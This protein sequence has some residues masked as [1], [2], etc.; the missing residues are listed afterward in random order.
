MDILYTIVAFLLLVG[1]IV[2]IHEGGH[3]IV[4]RMCGIKMMEFSIGFGPKIFSKRFGKDNTLFTLRAFPLGGFVKPFDQSLI[5]EQEW[6][7]VS[8]KDKK[9]TFTNA[10]RSKKALMVFGGP[11]ANFVLAFFLYLIALTFVGAKGYEPIIY[12]ISPESP[13]A[14]TTLLPGEKITEVNYNKVKLNGDVYPPLIN[15]MIQG[16][17]VVISTDKQKNINVDLSGINLR[18]VEK[19]AYSVLGLYFEGNIGDVM[20]DNVV[21]DSPASKAGLK[22]QDIILSVNGKELN[23]INKTIELIKDNPEKELSFVVLR[24]EEKINLIVKPEMVIEKNNEVG[25]VGASLSLINFKEPS[26]VYYDFNEAVWGSFVKVW[27]SSYTTLVSI[28][29]L[30]TGEFSTKSLSGPLSIAD[31]SGKSAKLGLFQYLIMMA[32]I[33]IAIGIFNL[34]PIPV[35]DGG[36]LLQYGIEWAFGKSVYPK[37]LYYTQVVGLGMLMGVF[38]MSIFNDLMKYI[39]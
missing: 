36:Y 21:K 20:I 8:E 5:S 25:K 27:D 2:A 19:N 34:L 31:Y 7:K 32:T 10:K 26:V 22:K 28:G 6:E 38:S 18:E 24:G 4:G 1:V 35:L 14:V 37:V 23:E 33:S 15:G 9:R 29:K 13:F 16:S 12:E 11:L 39:F 17:N 30:V 3:F